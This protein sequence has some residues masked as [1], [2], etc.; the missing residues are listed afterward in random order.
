ME[1]VNIHDAKSRLSFLITKVLKGERVVISRNNQPVAELV[2][3]EK[4]TR[5]PGKLKGKI[6][7]TEP[8]DTSDK[9]LMGMFEISEIF[10]E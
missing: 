6:T 3:L 8:L 2:P 1:T 10:P 7:Y 5:V 9:D 4:K